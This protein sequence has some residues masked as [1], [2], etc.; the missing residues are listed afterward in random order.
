[1]IRKHVYATTLTTLFEISKG[2]IGNYP[3]E[4]RAKLSFQLEELLPKYIRNYLFNEKDEIADKP[5]D[6]SEFTKI[7]KKYKPELVLRFDPPIDES[8]DMALILET[9]Q[10]VYPNL[11]W[12]AGESLFKYNPFSVGID[13]E[14]VCYLTIGFF[15]K[16]RLTYLDGDLEMSDEEIEIKGYTPYI[17]DGWTWLE[18]NKTDYEGIYDMLSSLD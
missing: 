16:D 1:M 10:K 11:L 8:I 7:I 14:S 4:D 13:V 9:L 17:K 12:Q 15:L 3:D 2:L 18:N 6:V 5:C